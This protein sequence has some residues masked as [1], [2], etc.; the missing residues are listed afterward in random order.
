MVFVGEAIKGVACFHALS[1]LCT[2]TFETKSPDGGTLC[3]C[4]C[5]HAR[6]CVCVLK[7]FGSQGSK[8]ISGRLLFLENE[9][10]SPS[11]PASTAQG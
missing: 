10:H 11:F 6:V 7:V 3:V 4:V 9:W 8:E 5:A 2:S 1:S